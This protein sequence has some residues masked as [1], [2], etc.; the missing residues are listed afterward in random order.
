MATDEGNATL[1]LFS[2]HNSILFA[3]LVHR[4]YCFQI[5][6]GMECLW[7]LVR[8]IK[9]ISNVAQCIRHYHWVHR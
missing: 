2:M 6:K 4:H 3:V 8:N 9:W 7:I 5:T 1:P